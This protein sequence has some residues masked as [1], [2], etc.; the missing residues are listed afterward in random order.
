MK[1]ALALLLCL[2]MLLTLSVG[3]KKNEE[4][5]KIGELTDEQISSDL[6]NNK[7]LYY[8]A[9]TGNISS[10][11]SLQVTDKKQNNNTI[12]LTATATASSSHINIALSANMKYVATN[13]AWELDSVEI[14]KS[15]PTITAGPDQ[16][17]LASEVDSYISLNKTSQ[18]ANKPLALAYYGEERHSL[19][20]NLSAVTWGVEY[21]KDAT[22]AK[23]TAEMKSDT[24][25][26]SGYYNLTFDQE[27]G[28]IIEGEMQ[29]HGQNYLVLHLDTLEQK[30]TDEK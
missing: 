23:L 26:F 9:H 1:K 24:L 2:M 30:T 18:E 17:T 12:T 13:G 4:A 27:R 19:N 25:T 28:W 5:K 8:Y 15:V 3:C 7:H 20:V 16:E 14:T 11:A 6:L 21:E 10:V 22:T 29:E